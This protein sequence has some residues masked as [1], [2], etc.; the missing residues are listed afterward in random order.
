MIWKPSWIIVYHPNRCHQNCLL[1]VTKNFCSSVGSASTL[2]SGDNG[3][4][5]GPKSW[6]LDW[7]I[8]W[9][10]SV[11]LTNNQNI[12]KDRIFWNVMSCHQSAWHNVTE[13]LNL[14]EHYFESLKSHTLWTCLHYRILFSWHF[15]TRFNS[16]CITETILIYFHCFILH[17][18]SL[19]F[20]YQ[21]MHFYVNKILV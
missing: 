6:Q 19:N 21:L 1:S 9:F 14:Q 11:R 15:F 20:I 13:Y 12:L 8:L 10:S 18:N 7:G 16:M 17:Y 4:D 2:Y 5:Y 3:F